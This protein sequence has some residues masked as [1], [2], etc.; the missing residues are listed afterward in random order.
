MD[1]PISINDEG[2]KLK[3]EKMIRDKLYNCIYND[4]IFLFYKDLEDIL[5]CYEITDEEIISKI[6]QDPENLEEIVMRFVNANANV[7]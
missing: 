3:P 7:S 2:V 5:H 6:K 4:K 1:K